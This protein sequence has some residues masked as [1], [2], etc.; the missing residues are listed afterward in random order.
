MNSGCSGIVTLSSEPV[1]HWEKTEVTLTC[2]YIGQ[3]SGTFRWSLNN[4]LYGEKSSSAANCR[5]ETWLA[6][7]TK[8]LYSCS[9]DTVHSV[10]IK[11]ITQDMHGDTW[12]C[13]FNPGAY[14][15]K[16]EKV[17][18]YVKGMFVLTQ[19]SL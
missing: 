3:Y 18:I 13:E 9:N 1:D 12:R 5:V 10:T 15:Y 14:T 11:N 19:C 6:N 8:Y 7:N 17:Q 16:S 2:S 4:T